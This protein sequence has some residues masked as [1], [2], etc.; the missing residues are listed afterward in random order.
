LPTGILNRIKTEIHGDTMVDC[1]DHHAL[2]HGTND[3]NPPVTTMSGTFKP[4][5]LKETFPV[6]TPQGTDGVIVER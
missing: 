4:K 1:M 2:L 6:N 3:V 5:T